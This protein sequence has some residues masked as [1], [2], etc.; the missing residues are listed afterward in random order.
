[1]TRAAPAG[2][3]GK[4]EYLTELAADGRSKCK[5]CKCKAE[6]RQG[7]L[8]IG[9]IPPRVNDAAKGKRIHWYHPGCIFE[10]FKKCSKR[11]FTITTSAHVV[12]FRKLHKRDR[13]RIS[14]LIR[15]HRAHL[16]DEG[17]EET[18]ARAAKMAWLA[19]APDAPSDAANSRQKEGE[20]GAQTSQ[21]GQI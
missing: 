3:I 15:D 17:L 8:R 16:R 2:R 18:A 21:P 20:P 7:E 14:E 11:T 9:K 10:S 4:N 19:P 1:M 6:I 12:G 5:N 13:D